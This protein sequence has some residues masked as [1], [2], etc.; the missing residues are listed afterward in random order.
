M[1]CENAHSVALV[2]ARAS[3]A[4]H[5]QEEL[6]AEVGDVPQGERILP[7]QINSLNSVGDGDIRTMVTQCRQTNLPVSLAGPSGSSEGVNDE[8]N[9]LHGDLDDGAEKASLLLCQ[10]LCIVNVVGQVLLC[11]G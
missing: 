10:R 8:G 9:K 6:E 11:W 5:R 2:D 4:G 1:K 7:V 3:A